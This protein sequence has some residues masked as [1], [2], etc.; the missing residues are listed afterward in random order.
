MSP[1]LILNLIAGI[2]FL[3]AAFSLTKQRD[4]SNSLIIVCGVVL[5]AA[6]M[7]VLSYAPVHPSPNGEWPIWFRVVGA[8]GPAG[9][10]LLAVAI[11][12]LSTSTVRRGSPN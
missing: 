1:E 4:L 11:Y 2:I 5:M 3:A 12:R 9:L 10:T 8:F 7:G 6:S